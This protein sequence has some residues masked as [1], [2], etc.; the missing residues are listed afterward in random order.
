[1]KSFIGLNSLTGDDH[2]PGETRTRV[3]SFNLLSKPLYKQGA[4]LR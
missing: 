4:M 2:E 1:M 3:N